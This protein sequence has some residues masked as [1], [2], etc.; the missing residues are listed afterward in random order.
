MCVP[1]GPFAGLNI[2]VGPGWLATDRCISRRINNGPSVQTTQDNLNACNQ[3]HTYE[4]AWS[5]FYL[6]PHQGCHGGV[7]GTVSWDFPA[8]PADSP[9][10]PCRSPLLAIFGVL[11]AFI[12]SRWRI[13]SPLLVTPFSS[14]TTRGWTRL[15]G[16]GRRGTSPRD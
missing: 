11:T 8:F 15:G 14:S 5:C 2:S 9:V 6:A 16:T 3:F 7:G 13:H 12:A 10:S 4:I 1:D